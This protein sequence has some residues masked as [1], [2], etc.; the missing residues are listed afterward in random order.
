M[1]LLGSGLECMT[2]GF[3]AEAS[4]PDRL[5]AWA[6]CYL[7]P[8]GGVLGGGGATGPFVGTY[9]SVSGLPDGFGVVCVGG[10]GVW[11]MTMGFSSFGFAGGVGAA[12]LPGSLTERRS[13]S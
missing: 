10:W 1:A 2:H 5:G 8:F 12:A 3:R 13:W 11:D 6:A 9:D 4:F 7:S